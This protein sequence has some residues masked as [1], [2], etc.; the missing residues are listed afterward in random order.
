MKIRS[1]LLLLA[2]GALVPPLV[3]AVAL[4]A[5]SWSEARHAVEVRQLERVRSIM[6]ALDTELQ[7]TIRVLRV[8]GLAPSLEGGAIPDAAGRL[9]TVLSTQPLWTLLA[10]GDPEWRET[11]AVR[12]AG[13]MPRAPA[14]DDATRRRVLQTRLPAVSPLVSLDGGHQTQV[15]VPVL[16]GAN[17]AML[18]MVAVDQSAWVGF[19][20][21]YPMAA[22]A[23][24]TLIDQNG[25]IIAR[26]LNNDRWVGKPPSPEVLRRSRT[27]AE[28][29]FRNVTLEG[30]PMY[31]AHSRSIRWGW[32]VAT[33]IPAGSVDESLRGSSLLLV[34]AAGLSIVLALA[35]ALFFGRRIVRPVKALGDSAH[36]LAEGSVPT[37]PA[38]API[39]EVRDV[40]VAFERASA[41]LRER[42]RA[43]NE[44][45]EGEQRARQDAEQA[46]RA[47][48]EFLAMLGHEL[49]NP[50]NAVAGAVGVLQQ[51]QPSPE[52]ALRAREIIARQVV[53]LRELVDDLLDV[54]RVTS[55]KIALTLR[56]VDLADV[57][58][59]TVMV[60]SGSGRLGRHSV[61]VQCES[62]WVS[63]DETRLEQIVSNL[64]DNAAKYTPDAGR[65]AVRV[66]AE[67][68]DALLEVEDSGMGIPA[69]LLPRIFDL[70][71]QGER[72]IDRAQGG[73]GLGLSLV[74]RLARLH[75]GEVTAT[76]AGAGKGARF[77]VRLPLQ[78][79]PVQAAASAP[80]V[81]EVERKL[82]ILIVEDNADGRETLAMMLGMQGH[83]VHEAEDG[84]S[85]VQ[86]A[87][88]VEPDAAIVDIGLP[89]FDGY[90]VARRVRATAQGTAVRLVALTGY[91]QDE[92]RKAAFDAGF[93]DFLVKPADLEALLRILGSVAPR[94]M[95]P[96]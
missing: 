21:Q 29:T 48:D 95:A 20:S 52:Q 27:M 40:A 32:T 25:V 57:A 50:L 9:R 66:R 82:R 73:L 75:G 67:G 18:L 26:T 83:E 42:Q 10:V 87:L 7:A 44:A 64:V 19:M 17:V 59:R 54:A 36:A 77:Q 62:A 65:I 15:V 39:R 96:H 56:P 89:G 49:R 85:G 11:V 91:G 74:R 47:K 30:D 45:L 84:P 63:G 34:S 16:E 24:M 13:L 71:T 43:L 12:H 8:I 28:S 22:G 37:P 94:A 92:D 78:G 69:D 2:A 38:T 86:R 79:A 14:I 5:H 55:G 81:D 46:S 23:V 41:M 53:S 51:P 88:D 1:H 35:L 70:F 31:S 68:T 33:G 3:F 90:E 61:D 80:I 93:D 6:I 60:M 76:S 58:R 4:T 72:T